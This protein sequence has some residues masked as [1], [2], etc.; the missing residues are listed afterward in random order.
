MRRAG[1][2]RG[3]GPRGEG[4]A[5]G[6][7]RGQLEEGAQVP[8]VRRAVVRRRRDLVGQHASS[9]RKISHTFGP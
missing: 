8:A 7:V 1:G 5:A 4:G 6:E 3:Y 9:H 2:V